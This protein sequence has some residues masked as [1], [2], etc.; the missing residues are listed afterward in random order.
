MKKPKRHH[1]VSAMLQRQ[2]TDDEGKLYFFQKDHREKGVIRS[3]P[4]NIFVKSDLYTQFDKD[5]KKNA[6]LETDYLSP[7]DSA[8]STNLQV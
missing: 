4:K 6:S 2:F 5:G 8:A 1:Y 3:S 7:L